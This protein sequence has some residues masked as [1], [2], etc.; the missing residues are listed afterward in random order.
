MRTRNLLPA[1]ALL[2]FAA[3]LAAQSRLTAKEQALRD[4]ILS[5]RADAI[6]YLQHVVDIPSSTL[7]LDGVRRV[8]DVFLASLDSLGFTTTWVPMPPAMGRAGHLVAEHRGKA[9]RARILLIGHFDTVVEPAGANFVREDSMA[10]AVG[11]SDMKGGDVIML[12]ALKALDEVGLLQDLNVTVFFSGDEEDPGS[13]LPVAR[14][15]LID[16]GHRN[17]VALAFEGGSRSIAT[18]ARRGSSAWRLTATGRQAHSAGVFGQ[19][20]GY[21]AIYELARILDAFRQQLAGEQYLTFNAATIVGGTDVVYDTVRESGTASSKLNIVPRTAVASGDLRFMTQEQLER[22]RERM[23]QIVAQH[24]P[25]TDAQITFIDEYPAMPLTPGNE[26]L[27]AYYD[28][29]SRALGYGPVAPMDPGMRGAGDLSFVA[30][31]MDGLEGLGALGSGA[32]SPVERVNLNALEMQT[33]RAALMLAR[34]GARPASEF[35]RPAGTA[36]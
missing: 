27:L 22:T 16:A 29:A 18:V 10:H 13:P 4:T 20:V 33:E 35:A 24:L 12:F 5:E 36:P 15:A 30:P 14:A 34:I 31:F 7:N 11:G 1:L 19:G 9:G 23:R 17:D 26:R 3:P 32:H 25:G 28:S 8:G 2:T 21:G 6:A